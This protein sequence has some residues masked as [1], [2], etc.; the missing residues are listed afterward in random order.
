MNVDFFLVIGVVF[1]YCRSHDDVTL[2]D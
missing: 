2:R 1:L